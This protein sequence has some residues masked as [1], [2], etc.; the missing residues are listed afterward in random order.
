MRALS[1]LLRVSA[2]LV[3]SLLA[4]PAEADRATGEWSGEAELRMN[5]YWETST[6]VVAPL[7]ALE[8][9]SPDGQR[10]GVDYLLDTITSASVAAG[11]ITDVHFT[12]LRHDVG[13][14][15]GQAFALSD[16]LEL[17]LGVRGRYSYEPDYESRSAGVSATLSFNDRASL[18]SLDLGLLDDLVGKKL[19]GA[20]RMIGGRDLSDRGTVGT[21]RVYSLGLRLSQVLSPVLVGE[22]GY[23]LA[24]LDGFQANPYRSVSVAGVLR[25]EAHP[26]TRTRHTLHGRLALYVRPT[27]SSLQV[28]YRAY[29]DDWDVAALT[30]ELRL[31]QELGDLLQARLRY[32]YYTQTRAYFMKA[33]IRYAESEPFVTSDPKMTEFHSH[34]LG[35]Q[36][37]LELEFLQ[38]TFL[39]FASGGSIDLSFERLWN[40]NRYGNAIL[41]QAGFRMPF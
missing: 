32:R 33:P 14:R 27:R 11:A 2:A 31:Y 6:R 25:D 16:D 41:S 35:L 15:A 18:L 3:L 24:Y 28:L 23:D 26:D 36:L 39:D 19:R 4:C 5:Y 38:D 30:P 13:L 22:L 1:Y 29:V 10:I 8:V 40:T 21:L 12:E 9:E 17:D 34:L 7:A 37:S 20:N